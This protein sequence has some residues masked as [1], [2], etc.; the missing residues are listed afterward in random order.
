MS[1]SFLQS[2][3]GEFPE[4][5]TDAV[6]VAWLAARFLR[7]PVPTGWQRVPS[8]LLPEGIV[9]GW[10]HASAF[11]E[12]R[13]AQS[14]DTRP[15]V[16]PHMRVTNRLEWERLW[17]LHKTGDC[18]VCHEKPDIWNGPMN[19]DVPT[20]CIHWACTSCW[21]MIAERDRRCPICREDLSA[22]FRDCERFR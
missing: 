5:A 18:P 20:R 21:E 11:V 4:S 13:G 8:S 1:F 17:D 22:W 12:H 15:L 16:T 6:C 10:F 19:S 2:A 7:P 14:T 3:E 9:V